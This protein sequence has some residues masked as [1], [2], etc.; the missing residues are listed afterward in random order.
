MRLKRAR[1][2]SSTAGF[3]RVEGSCVCLCKRGKRWWVIHLIAARDPWL[4]KHGFYRTSFPTR[5]EAAERLQDTLRLDPPGSETRGSATRRSFPQPD[6]V[7][8]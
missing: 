4:I 8:A 3:W 1:T 7:R 6:K 5:R 2:E